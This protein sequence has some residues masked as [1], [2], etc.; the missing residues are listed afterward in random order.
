M[1]V[2]LFMRT[3]IIYSIICFILSG[4]SNIID[5]SVFGEYEIAPK[6]INDRLFLRKMKADGRIVGSILILETD[7]TYFYLT[8]GNQITGHWRKMQDSVLLY[9]ETNFYRTDSM[10]KAEEAF[11]PKGPITFQIHKGQ[12]YRFWVMTDST[13][14]I[15]LLTKKN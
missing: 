7:S 6:T 9:V 14:Y 4:C 13:K 8:C 2:I 10:R 1:V 15:E 11:I 5:I 3:P 12:L